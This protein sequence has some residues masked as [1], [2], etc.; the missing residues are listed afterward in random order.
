MFYSGPLP[1]CLS[2]YSLPSCS[3][4]TV[5][6]L[7]TRTTGLEKGNVR[8]MQTAA[9]AITEPSWLPVLKRFAELTKI[10]IGFVSVPR[11]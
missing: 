4:R 8:D 2:F 7:V 10:K 1:A 6:S 9:S 5:E 11:F 3:I